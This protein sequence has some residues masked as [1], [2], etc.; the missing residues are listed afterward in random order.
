MSKYIAY[1]TQDQAVNCGFELASLLR[2][3]E[4]LSRQKEVV[5]C[6]MTVGSFAALK[7]VGHPDVADVEQPKFGAA[8]F[9]TSN[10]D[11]MSHDELATI[12]EHGTNALSIIDQ[13]YGVSPGQIILLVKLAFW[14][15][16]K[17]L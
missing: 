17:V 5:A 15:V 3:G 13:S 2:N 1:A 8:Q 9:T 14:L 7:M 11:G 10:F 16:N 12:V 6:A 4:A